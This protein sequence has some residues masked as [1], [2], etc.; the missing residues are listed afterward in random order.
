MHVDIHEVSTELG[1]LLH[2][3]H[4]LRQK[5]EKKVLLLLEVTFLGASLCPLKVYSFHGRNL[6]TF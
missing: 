6:F 3:D 5:L 1:V 2:T 4:P